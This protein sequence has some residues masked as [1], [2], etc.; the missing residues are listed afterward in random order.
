[1]YGSVPVGDARAGPLSHAA[2]VSIDLARY[3]YFVDTDDV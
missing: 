1:M 3:A 2:G